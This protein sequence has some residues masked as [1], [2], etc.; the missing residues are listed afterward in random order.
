M[1]ICI[2]SGINKNIRADSINQKKW[3][4]QNIFDLLKRRQIGGSDG[5]KLG[6][7]CL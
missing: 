7:E 4:R 2:K 3:R 1:Q 6:S 5:H